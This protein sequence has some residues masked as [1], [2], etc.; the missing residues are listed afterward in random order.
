MEELDG[1]EAERVPLFNDVAPR[2]AD[3]PVPTT[4]RF[5]VAC[6]KAFGPIGG[7]C[8]NGRK[9][10]GFMEGFIPNGLDEGPTGI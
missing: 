8:F 2:A 9:V 5:F 3:Q 7:S 6:V 4:T 1:M 10:D